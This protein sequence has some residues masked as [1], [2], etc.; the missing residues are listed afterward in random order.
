MGL[1]WERESTHTFQEKEG[2]RS[3]APPPNSE[4]LQGAMEVQQA[5]ACLHGDLRGLVYPDLGHQGLRLGIGLSHLQKP[6]HSPQGP[7]S[8]GWLW[9]KP[10]VIMK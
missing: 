9:L 4:H 8:D 6:G 7:P 5:I 2:Y 1:E 3:L 10:G